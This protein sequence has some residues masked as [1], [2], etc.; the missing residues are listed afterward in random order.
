MELPRLMNN[1]SLAAFFYGRMPS[2][3]SQLEEAQLEHRQ[4]MNMRQS[5][6]NLSEEFQRRQDIQIVRTPSPVMS[7]EDAFRLCMARIESGKPCDPG[8]GLHPMEHFHCRSDGCIL[9]A[10]K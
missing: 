6:N 2:S 4:Q 9:L 1:P 5:A 7:E 8:C 10:F 3:L